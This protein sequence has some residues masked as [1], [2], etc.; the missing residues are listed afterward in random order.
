MIIVSLNNLPDGEQKFIEVNQEQFE[1]MEYL[2]KIGA[3]NSNFE[4]EEI[5]IESMVR[6]Y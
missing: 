3:F 4:F 1:L 2:D 5:E 6:S